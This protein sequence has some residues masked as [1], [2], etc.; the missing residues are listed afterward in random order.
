MN[1]DA[2]H[3]K[4][5][6]LRLDTM[7]MIAAAGAGH[8]GSS[9]STIEILTTLHYGVMS[10]GRGLVADRRQGDPLV[11]DLDRDRFVLSKGHAAPA[12]YAVL[13]DLGVLPEG[14]CGTLR[15]LGSPLQG[16][17]D[18][19]LTPGVEVSSGS[20]GQ[21]FSVA[22]GIA[23]GL[24]HRAARAR[25]FALLGDGECQEGQVWEAAMAAGQLGLDG[26]TA[27]VDVNG[28]QHDGPTDAIMGAAPLARK[29]ESFGWETV[30]VDG[31]DCAALVEALRPRS[32]P[33]AV[34]A[35]TVKGRGVS[36]MEGA[37]EWHSV[38]DQS[39]LAAAVEE[40]SHA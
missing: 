20:L 5:D 12:L 17:P 36:F 10:P 7:R 34:M 38:C 37:V 32:R 14:T 18:S 30:T 13:L 6:Q 23:L 9:L 33:T 4:A 16:H 40:L 22:V 11:T 29:W 19:R 21:A 31:H 26:L 8:P 35:R 2:L 27:I 15:S 3:S 25:V 1:A 28:I 39:R 24:R